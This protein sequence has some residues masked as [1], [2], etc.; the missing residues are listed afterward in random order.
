[1]VIGNALLQVSDPDLPGDTLTY[2]VTSA[3]A[4]ETLNLGASF[5]QAQ[6]DANGLSYLHDGSEVT[7][8]GF[9]FSVSDG[10][11]GSIGSTVFALTLTPVHPAPGV[12]TLGF[13]LTCLLVVILTSVGAR[14]LYPSRQTAQR[15]R[16]AT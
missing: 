12:P 14:S 15:S 11:G 5:T 7:S 16:D 10:N 8:D 4:T 2:T 13:W 6:I 1:V 3:P 9:T